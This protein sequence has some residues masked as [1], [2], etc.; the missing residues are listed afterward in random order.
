MTVTKT[1]IGYMKIVKLSYNKVLGN[2]TLR[3]KMT[4]RKIFQRVMYKNTK[5]IF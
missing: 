5:G 3:I 4:V 2:M 1:D